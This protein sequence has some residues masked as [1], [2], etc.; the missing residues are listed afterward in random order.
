[1]THRD[2]NGDDWSAWLA[3]HGRAM[4]LFARQWAASAADAEDVVQEA[5]L[6]FWRSRDRAGDPSAYL[7]ACVRHAALDL[8]R[9]R[10]RREDRE[11]PAARPELTADWFTAGPECRE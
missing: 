8:R 10:Q 7:Y 2:D 3:R 9:G 6:R 5:F 1:M 4:L 11:R